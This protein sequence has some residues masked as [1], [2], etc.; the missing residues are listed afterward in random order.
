MV[1]H[2]FTPAPRPSP[3]PPRGAQRKLLHLPLLL[4]PPPP[5]LLLRAS[6]SLTVS[7]AIPLPAAPLALAL[8]HNLLQ[9]FPPLQEP[10]SFSLPLSDPPP[11]PPTLPF[12]QAGGAGQRSPKDANHSRTWDE[13]CFQ[14][15][16]YA[17]QCLDLIPDLKMLRLLTW[18]CEVET[19]Q[20]LL[21][22]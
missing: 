1:Q 8:S 13:L 3:P 11:A 6:P 16:G 17:A 4:Q 14:L 5:Q 15:L 2:P 22:S 19:A 21:V 20:P 18:S 10:D 12:P 7:S 9:T